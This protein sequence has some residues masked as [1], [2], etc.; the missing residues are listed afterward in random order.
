MAKFDFIINSQE[1]QLFARPQ[2]LDVEKS[3]GKLPRLSVS[4]IFERLKE[5]TQ[6]D[7]TEVEVMTKEQYE[8]SLTDLGLFVKKIEPFLKQLKTDLASFLSKKQQ[9]MQ[10]YA[11]TA[12][13]LT[14]YE[15]LNL[16]HYTDLD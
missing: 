4:Q 11:G 15:D 9:V 3:L 5:A 7:E 6:T 10:C 12:K 13:V 2:G 16:A 14:D 8:A 1:F